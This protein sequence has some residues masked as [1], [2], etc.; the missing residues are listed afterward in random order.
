MIFL[1]KPRNPGSCL[2]REWWWD[3]SSD[4]EV[5]VSLQHELES[6]GRPKSRAQKAGWLKAQRD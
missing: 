6:V 4:C 1:A 2:G 5:R 3:D